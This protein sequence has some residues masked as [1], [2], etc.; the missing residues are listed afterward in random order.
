MTKTI[1]TVNQ[2][3]GFNTAQKEKLENKVAYNLSDEHINKV[4]HFQEYGIMPEL[5]GRFTRLV[6]FGA[7]GKETLRE[8]LMEN[9][10]KKYENEL[11]LINS[12]LNIDEKVIDKI[13][14]YL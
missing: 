6:P 8:I 11:E 1:N 13:I 9:V 5:M 2:N 4:L 3:I 7:L 12:K 10:L 14:I